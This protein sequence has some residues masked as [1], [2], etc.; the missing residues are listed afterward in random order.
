MNQT[1][2]LFAESIISTEDK[3]VI[4]DILS[5]L[6]PGDNP[7]FTAAFITS[8]VL[9][10]YECVEEADIITEAIKELMPPE[11]KVVEKWNP[12]W[13]PSAQKDYMEHLRETEDGD[14]VYISGIR[15]EAFEAASVDADDNDTHIL[16]SIA[17]TDE[18]GKT[19]VATNICYTN[20][21]AA[22]IPSMDEVNKHFASSPTLYNLN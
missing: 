3:Q 13:Y 15:A 2:L 7:V 11:T 17:L 6:V 21:T 20:L 4:S 22:M 8:E 10:E 14:S 16:K 19:V 18:D 12:F 5:V 1:Q 9:T